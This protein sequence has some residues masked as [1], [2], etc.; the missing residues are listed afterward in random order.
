MKSYLSALLAG[1]LLLCSS[2][3]NQARTIIEV[4]FSGFFT[5][6]EEAGHPDYEVGDAFSFSFQMDDS[7][8]VHQNQLFFV[9]S[10]ISSQLLINDV[11]TA[12]GPMSYVGMELFNDSDYPPSAWNYS[13]FF[14]GNG[15]VL[16]QSKIPVDSVPDAP[17]VPF[18]FTDFL[19]FDAVDFTTSDFVLI[20]PGDPMRDAIR[21][22]VTS[23]S[24]QV[25]PEPSSMVLTL[26]VAGGAWLLNRRRR[27][28]A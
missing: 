14:A 15:F 22:P 21:G 20:G 26:G 24:V 23:I 27:V 25:I 2:Q 16:N 12:H 19:I 4:S 1:G 18:E 9:T 8:L 3:E 13:I 5:S 28:A 10:L 6:I 7:A 11:E 17:S